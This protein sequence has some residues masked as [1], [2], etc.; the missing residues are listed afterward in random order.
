[1]RRRAP[2]FTLIEM[3][4]VLAIMALLAGA[5]VVS[6][7]GSRRRVD[8][9]D[10]VEQIAQADASVRA[11]ARGVDTP[12][13]MKIVL[14]TGQLFRIGP[15]A[16][17]AKLAELPRDVSIRRVRIGDENVDSGDLTVEIS[18]R[19]ASPSYAVRVDDTAGEHQWVVAAGLTGQVT[20]VT[21]EEL[22]SIFD[23]VSAPAGAD[24]R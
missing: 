10:A 18:S 15:D 7:H 3:V 19:G 21:D 23:Q 5:A 4:G 13:G 9:R 11:V 24:A 1:M 12:V 14:S 2:A 20:K 22:D 16:V 8:L 6:L 17:T